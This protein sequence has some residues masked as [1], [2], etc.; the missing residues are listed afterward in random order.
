[1]ATVAATTLSGTNISFAGPIT[2]TVPGTG[3]GLDAELW[4]GATKTIST[5]APSGG[6]DGD[7]WFQYDA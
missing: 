3:T 7:I 4:D 5:G 6:V 1:A 2:Q